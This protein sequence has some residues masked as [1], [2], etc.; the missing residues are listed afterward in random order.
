MF[1]TS[2]R[3]VVEDDRRHQFAVVHRFALGVAENVRAFVFELELISI[4]RTQFVKSVDD[5][6]VEIKTEEIKRRQLT[7]KGHQIVA[8][9]R[10]ADVT[11]IEQISTFDAPRKVRR[12]TEFAVDVTLDAAFA[13]ALVL[14][15]EGDHVPFARFEFVLNAMLERFLLQFRAGNHQTIA[16]EMRAVTVTFRRA[17]RVE[18]RFLLF[19]RAV[20]HRIDA[21]PGGDGEPVLVRPCLD[22]RENE[23]RTVST[24]KIEKLI[25]SVATRKTFQDV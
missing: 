7:G 21:K 18:M 20:H 11:F 14:M 1:V 19:D 4:G 23:T 5:R 25:R 3:I 9:G 16:H 24:W 12:R 10:A 22:R 13:P 15:S 6:R 2:D 8:I 17:E